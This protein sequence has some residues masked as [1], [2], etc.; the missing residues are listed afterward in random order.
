MVDFLFQAHIDQFIID[1]IKRKVNCRRIY[2]SQHRS[3]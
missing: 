3:E 1:P 2:G